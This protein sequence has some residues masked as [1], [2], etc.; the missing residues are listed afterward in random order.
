MSIVM[1]TY[2]ADV[3]REVLEYAY[4]RAD[5][6]DEVVVIYRRVIM[7]GLLTVQTYEYIA[8]GMDSDIPEGA[9]IFTAIG[10]RS[11]LYD[12]LAGIVKEL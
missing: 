4:T 1:R 7:G 11:P 5:Q 8:T 3:P 12:N 9:E 6:N 10:P 2:E